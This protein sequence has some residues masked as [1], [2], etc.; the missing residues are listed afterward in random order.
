MTA[1]KG[2]THPWARVTARDIM[3][4]NVITI[5]ATTPLSDVERLLSDN[6]IT[7]APVTNEAGR[8]VGVIS[9]TDL[10]AR[11]SEDPDAR[12]RRGRGYFHLSNAELDDTSI[13]SFEVPA[14]SEETAGDNMTAQVFAVSADA[15]LQTVAACMTDHGIHRVLVQEDER[16]IGLI[17]TMEVLK[18]LAV[19]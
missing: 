1:N 6:G 12:P 4:T 5:S 18:V 19:Q 11:Y 2:D 9:L 14:E 3:R 13:D 16:T 10:V 7:G 17:S 8:I 15:S